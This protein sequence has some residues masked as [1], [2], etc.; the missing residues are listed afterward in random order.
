MKFIR[1]K[2]KGSSEIKKGWIYKENLVGEIEGDFFSEYRRLEASIPL[3]KIS[4][5][6]PVIP[7]KIIGIGWNY[8][9]HSENNQ[10]AIPDLPTIFLKSPSAV[11]GPNES[12]VLPKIAGRVE[13]GCALACVI[14]K[15]ARKITP[16]DAYKVI[17]GYTIA[18]DITAVD[19]MKK[20]ETW[21][22]AKNFD[23]FCPLGPSIE[24]DFILA[25]A[26]ITCRIN[27]DLRQMAS[28]RDMIFSV[29]SLIAYISSI[30]TLNPG[31]IIITGTP[32]G[33]GELLPDN[34]I[35]S[36]IDKLGTMQNTVI[37]EY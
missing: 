4:L 8:I 16:D 7:G 30:M 25:D 26:L 23:T 14:G 18:N 33:M 21:A 13:Y 31:D 34:V 17:F 27:S 19:L 2:E 32:P 24:T 5:L 11:I 12:I 15:T 6:A 10:K 28:T 36:Q 37:A 22:R 1:Y 20:D 29:S 9:D 35:E 3:E